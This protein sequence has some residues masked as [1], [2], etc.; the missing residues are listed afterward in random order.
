MPSFLRM[1]VNPKH[2]QTMQFANPEYFF[3]LLLLIP[4]LLWYF[5]IRGLG[6]PTL[7]MATTEQYRNV[8]RTFRTPLYICRLCYAR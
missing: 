2:N 4:I 8:P 3:L 6:E 1:Q 5:L 7:R